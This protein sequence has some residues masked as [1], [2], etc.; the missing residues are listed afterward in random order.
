[1]FVEFMEEEIIKSVKLNSLCP[2]FLLANEGGL[3]R[4]SWDN[5][6]IIGHSARPAA[7]GHFRPHTAHSQWYYPGWLRRP[8]ILHPLP[9]P[10]GPAQASLF[11]PSLRPGSPASSVTP[12]P[13]GSP[14]MGFLTCHTG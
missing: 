7:S 1:M 2:P 11:P 3:A 4:C 5:G 12:H 9:P 13:Q 14:P 8:P 6:V 10:R